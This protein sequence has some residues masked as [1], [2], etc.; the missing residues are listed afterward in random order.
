MDHG[1]GVD[2]V[3]RGAVAHGHAAAFAAAKE[4]RRKKRQE[5]RS[6]EARK[7]DKPTPST[8]NHH[9]FDGAGLDALHSDHPPEEVIGPSGK[10]FRSTSIF[11]L[12]PHHWPRVWAIHLVESKLFDPII[13]LAILANCFT[14]AWQSPLEPAGTPKALFIDQCEW[15]FLGI[16]TFELLAKILAYGFLM[17]PG[18]YLRDGWCQLDFI[19]VSLAWLP[20]IYPSFGNFSAFRSVRALRPLRALKRVPG[21][22]VLVKSIMDAV[23]RLFTVAALCGAVL[24]VFGIVG[25]ETFKGSLHHHCTSGDGT[26][27]EDAA[28]RTEGSNFMLSERSLCD[29]DGDVSALCGAGGRCVYYEASARANTMSFD[30][31]GVAFVA[32]LQAI[33]F[34]DY[35][36]IMCAALCPTCGALLP[37][38]PH[39]VL[40]CPKGP[41]PKG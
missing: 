41:R 22:P 2:T 29:P 40:C 23:P 21:M 33:T 11:C 27:G 38:A 37:Y 1:L 31:L 9:G 16:F 39:A 3:H 36:V 5:R 14:L 30:H 35:V 28:V 19:V 4:E 6:E 15:A 32:L 24:F 20:I 18:S 7:A 13:L 25:V 12:R 10:V 17:H 8:D 34:D 26:S